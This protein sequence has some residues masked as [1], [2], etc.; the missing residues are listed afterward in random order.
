MSGSDAFGWALAIFKWIGNLLGQ[1]VATAF[2]GVAFWK[3]FDHALKALEDKTKAHD[4]EELERE[5]SSLQ[6][7]T[8]RLTAELNAELERLKKELGFETEAYKLRLKKQELI[9]SRELEA[10][11]EFMTLRRWI[12]PKFEEPDKDWSDVQREVLT[13]FGKYEPKIETFLTKHGPIIDAETV[14]RLELALHNASFRK[15][16]YQPG[17]LPD[18]VLQHAADQFLDLL[19]EVEKDLLNKVRN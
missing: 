18:E 15:F 5:K 11:S 10:A 16:A 8:V 4:N 19:V 12:E 17:G 9:F 14:K 3:L 1:G 2:F 7:E 6:K 13:N